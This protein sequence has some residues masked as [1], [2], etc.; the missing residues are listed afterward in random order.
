MVA[1]M[2]T[3]SATDGCDQPALGS[4]M[5]LLATT[6]PPHACGPTDKC[7]YLPLHFRKL[8]WTPRSAHLFA[9][10]DQARSRVSPRLTCM[11]ERPDHI[12]KNYE[13]KRSIA[14]TR[15]AVDLRVP[16]I[17]AEPA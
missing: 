3:L 9:V 6:F 16:W 10:R 4:T 12:I 2:G 13:T 17:S 14:I 8:D 7:N 11:Q 5:A 15:Q 1:I